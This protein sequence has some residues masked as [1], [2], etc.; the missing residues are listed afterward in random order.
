MTMEEI[1]PL[2]ARPNPN[3]SRLAGRSRSLHVG[4]SLGRDGVRALGLP[5]LSLVEGSLPGFDPDTRVPEY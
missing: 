5:V 3:L 2:R 4:A 1:G